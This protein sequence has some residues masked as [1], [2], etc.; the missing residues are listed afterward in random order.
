M[1]SDA[2]LLVYFAG[3][4]TLDDAERVLRA[5]WLTVDRD[6]DLLAVRGEGPSLRV[7]W[8]AAP[9]VQLEAR[10]LA[11]EHGLYDLVRCDRRFEVG[12]D[13]LD[14]VLDDINTLIEVEGQLQELTGGCAWTSW[15]GNL[16]VPYPAPRPPFT[17]RP[18][19]PGLEVRIV[20]AGPTRFVELLELPIAAL[21]DAEVPARLGQALRALPPIAHVA[22]LAGE[23]LAGALVGA[24][25]DW[26][27]RLR[28]AV[29]DGA[30]ASV[31]FDWE[32]VTLDPRNAAAAAR[33]GVV[34]ARTHPRVI[35]TDPDTNTDRPWAA[36]EILD[37][38]AG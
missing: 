15:N 19:P 24:D 35:A 27:A 4:A 37:A 1:G 22:L 28:A 5:T 34:I 3:A 2:H 30:V 13:D 12:F 33:A 20:D 23:E 38:V 29:P 8:S 25:D 7:V 18:A 11:D 10:E 14:A 9:H 26:W 16:A 32:D 17:E 21:L 6:G 36:D 31:F